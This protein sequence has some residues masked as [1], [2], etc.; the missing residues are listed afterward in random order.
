MIGSVRHPVTVTVAIRLSS[1][2]AVLRVVSLIIAIFLFHT[3]YDGDVFHRAGNVLYHVNRFSQLVT[4]YICKP[5]FQLTANRFF[6]FQ[7]NF[8]Q[9]V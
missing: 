3:V 1:V 8:V 6:Q 7:L 5:V 4:I 2:T 9:F